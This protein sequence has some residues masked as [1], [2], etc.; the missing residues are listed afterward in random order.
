M[1]INVCNCKS[2][3]LSQHVT[4][5]CI[6]FRANVTQSH[7]CGRT[8]EV[9]VTAQ[10]LPATFKLLHLPSSLTFCKPLFS[11]LSNPLHDSV[12]H[13]PPSLVDVL[14]CP[15]DLI[16]HRSFFPTLVHAVSALVKPSRHPRFCLSFFLRLPSDLIWHRSFLLLIWC[17]P[18]S[19]LGV[20]SF[21]WTRTSFP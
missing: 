3:M 17:Q 5:L 8:T 9:V 13:I 21:P 6:G 4:S 18:L 1:M 15:N 10:N 12:S 11:Y 14:H 7:L 16:W 19:S 20:P 2:N